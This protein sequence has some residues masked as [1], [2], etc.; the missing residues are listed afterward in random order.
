M[1]RGSKKVENT[2]LGYISSVTGLTLTKNEKKLFRSLERDLYIRL[3]LLG[4]MREILSVFIKVLRLLWNGDL[5][6]FKTNLDVIYKSLV[7]D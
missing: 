1:C 4:I 5:N 6:W 3:I 2:Y 7:C